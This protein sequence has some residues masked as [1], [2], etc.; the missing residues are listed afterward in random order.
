MLKNLTLAALALTAVAAQAQSTWSSDTDKVD[1]SMN[2]KTARLLDLKNFVIWHANKVSGATDAYT[3]ECFLNQIPS[4]YERALLV[5]L[6][7][8]A[9]QSHQIKDEKQAAVWGGTM[10]ST[11]YN[12]EDSSR[13]MRMI[14]DKA[15]PTD[16]SHV[17]AIK[18]VTSGLD[19]VDK[20][21]IWTLFRPRPFTETLVPTT[22]NEAALDAIT[23]YIEKNA[24]W[25]EPARLKYTSMA[26]RSW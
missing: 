21:L 7:E 8:N 13:P 2:P 26:P 4:N 9:L 16:V 20:G 12:V 22:M 17:E 24:S 11:N 18:V 1:W 5:G 23:R 14:A 15:Q 19:I 6:A 3:L 10:A 25:T